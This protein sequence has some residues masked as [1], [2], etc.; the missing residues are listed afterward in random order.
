[1]Y[2]QRYGTPPIVHA[3]GGLVDTVT[4]CT[5]ETLA[6][7]TATGFQFQPFDRRSLLDV[8]AMANQIYRERQWYCSLQQNGMER[9]FGWE[10]GAKA[11][12]KLYERLAAAK[13]LLL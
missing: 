5:S 3:T 7:G 1:M 8:I 12:H 13:G 2:S 9:D 4:H 6:N 11:Y 10:V